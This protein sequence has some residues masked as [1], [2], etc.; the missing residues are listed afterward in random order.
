MLRRNLLE[1]GA[2]REVGARVP[3][4][5][6]RA[7]LLGPLV[8]SALQHGPEVRQ[9]RGHGVLDEAGGGARALG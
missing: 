3:D 5:G 4:L 2:V 7:H 1:E 8:P 6:R 9:E